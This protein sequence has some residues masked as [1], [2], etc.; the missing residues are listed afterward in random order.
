[1]TH[2]AFSDSPSVQP[3]PPLQRGEPQ[4]AAQPALSREAADFLIELSVTLQKRAM[5]PPGHP[6]LKTST[7]RLMRRAEVLLGKVPIA[8]FGVARD[9]LIVDGAATDARTT[10]SVNWP[11]ASIAI[12]SRRSG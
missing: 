7:E 1:M 8:V 12:G 11:I 5:Y 10:S 9:Q 4:A 3:P 6:Y 2:S